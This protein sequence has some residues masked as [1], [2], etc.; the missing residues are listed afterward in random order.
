MSSFEW[1]I[2]GTVVWIGVVGLVIVAA[3][4]VLG[5]VYFE[6]ASSEI[7]STGW[8]SSWFPIYMVFGVFLVMGGA[9]WLTGS[10]SD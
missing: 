4:N 9:L 1:G 5:L 10:S 8:W 7:F 2:G 6:L 3:V